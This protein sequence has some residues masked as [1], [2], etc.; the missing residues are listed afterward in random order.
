MCPERANRVKRQRA[1]DDGVFDQGDVAFNRVL[2][3]GN[4]DHLKHLLDKLSYAL[5]VATL[6]NKIDSKFSDSLISDD[7]LTTGSPSDKYLNAPLT[8]KV[9]EVNFIRL[10]YSYLRFYN[11]V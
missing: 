6:G 2:T 11:R 10:C 3:P 1:V 8:A 4:L 7:L 9:E 5:E